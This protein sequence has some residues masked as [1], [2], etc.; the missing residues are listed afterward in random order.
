[1]IRYE[2]LNDTDSGWQ[3]MAGNEDEE[4]TDDHK[5]LVL[6]RLNDVNELDPDIWEYID[7]PIGT[8]FIR[9]SSDKFEED[10]KDKK[11]FIEKR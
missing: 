3:F 6:L 9:V 2:P 11:I 5:N 10:H 8:S 1:M 4:Y 7:K